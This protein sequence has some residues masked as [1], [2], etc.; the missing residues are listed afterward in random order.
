MK[1]L[2][3]SVALLALLTA[4]CDSATT[5]PET[6]ADAA[7]DAMFMQSQVSSA[8]LTAPDLTGTVQERLAQLN[9]LL[10]EAGAGVAIDKI[11]WVTTGAADEVG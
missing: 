5:N 4:A 9:G 11:E 1:R 3:L 2:V 10:A 8:T 7:T 6:Q